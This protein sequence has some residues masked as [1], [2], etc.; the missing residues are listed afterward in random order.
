[1][2][3]TSIKDPIIEEARSLQSAAGRKQKK[4]V[5]LYGLEQLK[6]ALKGGAFLEHVF[7]ETGDTEQVNEFNISDKI[8]EVSSGILKKISDTKYVVPCLAV[9]KLQLP[10]EEK[11]DFL[12]VLEGLCDFGNIGSIIRTAKGFSVNQF[13]F[14]TMQTDPFQRKTIDASRG[15]VLTS[16]ILQK[17]TA[18]KSIQYLK[19]NNYQ[20][21]V[22]SPHAKSLQSQVPLSL[23][24]VAL[25]IGNETSGVSEDFI[26]AADIAIQIPMSAQVESLN[27]SVSAGIS[28]YELK[29]KQVLIMLKEKIFTNFGRQVGVTGKLMRMAFDKE[30]KQCT[31]LSGMQVILL[32][33]MHCDGEMVKEQITRDTGLFGDELEQF[34]IPLLDHKYI[35]GEQNSYLLTS[36]GKRFIAEIWPV[37]ERAH[38]KITSKMSNDEIVLLSELLNKLQE[39]CMDIINR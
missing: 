11:S 39:G 15:L 12:V 14:S 37:V 22:T 24:K 34:L 30:I 3:I 29:F 33:I 10:A 7:V 13:L 35:S 31:D 6:W 27:V 25:I 23:Q 20:I 18:Q 5:L 36:D 2:K 9:I 28:I 16:N 38:Q 17:E 19:D 8:I 21:V 1:M 26:N 32:M 4:K